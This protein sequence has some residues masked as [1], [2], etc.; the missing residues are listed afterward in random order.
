M[1]ADDLLRNDGVTLRDRLRRRGRITYPSAAQRDEVV[2][3][4]CGGDFQKDLACS[5]PVRRREPLRLRS[6]IAREG[7]RF[8]QS[9]GTLTAAVEATFERIDSGCPLLRVSHQPDTLVGL[10]TMEPLLT[11]TELGASVASAAGL[12]RPALLFLV[13]DYDVAADERF[14][15][16]LLPCPEGSEVL[17]LTDPVPKRLRRQIAA[18]IPSVDGSVLTSWEDRLQSSIEGWSQRTKTGMEDMAGPAEALE[19]ITMLMDMSRDAAKAARTLT[20]ANSMLMS[21]LCNEVWGMDAIFLRERSLWPLIADDL[22]G[23]LLLSEADE[24]A[25][26]ARIGVWRLCGKCLRRR[27]AS[28]VASADAPPKA[29]WSCAR[30]H[31]NRNCEDLDWSAVEGSGPRQLPRFI[32]K[33]GLSDLADLYSYGIA[34]SA[35]YAGGIQHVVRTRIWGRSCLGEAPPEL[36]VDPREVFAPAGTYEE[37]RNRLCSPSVWDALQAGKYPAAFYTS[38]IP[39]GALPSRRP[40]MAITTVKRLSSHPAG[41]ISIP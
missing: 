34:G 30:C 18:S 27:S 28:I 13:V 41:P 5:L 22:N 24:E 21:K 2:V 17:A 31:L 32:P 25:A 1:T 39:G 16:A 8:H 38:L 7:R 6:L 35:S 11:L 40:R 19:T 37:M 9:A 20:E 12:L 29:V 23:F 36:V 14:R 10:N 33:V 3:H 15:R 4:G 26:A